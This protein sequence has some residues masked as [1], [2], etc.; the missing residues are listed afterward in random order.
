MDD[1][2]NFRGKI[3]KETEHFVDLAKLP[4]NGKAADR[5]AQDGICILVN[6]NGYT[7][8]ARNEIF[9]LKPAPLQVSGC[10]PLPTHSTSSSQH[11]FS[12][13]YGRSMLCTSTVG[14]YA[15]LFMMNSLVCITPTKMLLEFCVLDRSSDSV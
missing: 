6:M 4:C 2:T 8:G 5:I 3:E 12:C 9:A 13:W 11:G 14:L 10:S 15:S 1:K 7:K